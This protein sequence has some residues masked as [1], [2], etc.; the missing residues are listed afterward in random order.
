MKLKTLLAITIVALM[1]F[2]INTSD[3]QVVVKLRPSPPVAKKAKK[4]SKP[5]M[6]W[7]EGQWKWKRSAKGY[8]WVK[9]YWTKSKKAKY[10]VSGYWIRTRSGHKW[11]PGHWMKV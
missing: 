11:I 8:A 6:I 1:L 9:G 2:G 7:V 3:A 4:P 5:G 10:F